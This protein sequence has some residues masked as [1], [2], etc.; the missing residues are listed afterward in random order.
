MNTEMGVSPKTSKGQ[1]NPAS[2]IAAMPDD[3]YSAIREV[4]MQRV[5]LH[6]AEKRLTLQIKAICR[7][8]VGGD[9]G[10]AEKLYQR[11]VKND[12][13]DLADAVRVATSAL[14]IARDGIEAQRKEYEKQLVKL[15]KPLPLAAWVAGVKGVGQLMLAQLLG[16]TG[17]PAQYRNRSCFQKR[18]GLAVINGGRQRRVA[19]AEALDH[20]YNAERRS[21]VWNIGTGMLKAQGKGDD[22]LYYRKVYDERKAME[23]ERVETDGHAHNRAKRYMEKRFIRDLY[24]E[25]KRIAEGQSL[26]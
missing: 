18:L 4:Y 12:L 11:I 5:D 25:A 2:S 26:H 22:A 3:V 19:G 7:R 9:K 17:D 23:R 24:N 15:V 20:G 14:F 21:L 10:D 6:R 1:K 8:A 13:D 16:E